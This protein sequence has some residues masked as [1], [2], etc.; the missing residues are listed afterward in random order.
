MSEMSARFNAIGIEGE[1]GAAPSKKR[2]KKKKRRRKVGHAGLDAEKAVRTVLS[3]GSPT[4]EPLRLRPASSVGSSQP[5]AQVEAMAAAVKHI[6]KSTGIDYS[7][8][9]NLVV[10]SSDDE[11]FGAHS[12]PQN[13]HHHTGDLDCAQCRR[14]SEKS[15]NLAAPKRAAPPAKPARQGIDYSKWDHIDCTDSE[16]EL[17]DD[18]FYSHGDGFPSTAD[19]EPHGPV[20]SF[21]D[22]G[23]TGPVSPPDGITPAVKQVCCFADDLH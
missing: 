20:D 22:A 11:D 9:D 15:A 7:K 8:W 21:E 23:S 4:H 16:D 10:S 14:E 3:S 19:L 1:I 18:D 17:E 5:N 2:K 13:D 12:S 6:S